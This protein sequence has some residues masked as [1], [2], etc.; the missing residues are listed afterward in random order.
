MLSVF[1][2]CKKL[3]EKGRTDGLLDKLDSYLANDRLTVDEYNE[4]VALME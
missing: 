1:N 4:L 3:I 2:L